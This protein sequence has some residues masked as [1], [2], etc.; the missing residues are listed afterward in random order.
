MGIYPK[1][2]WRGPVPNQG[3]ARSAAPRVGVVHIMEGTLSGTDAWFHNPASQ[4][5][6]HFGIGKDGTVY[7][8]VDTMAVA[9]HAAAANGYSVGVEHEGNTGDVLTPAQLAADADL[10]AWLTP[11]IALTESVSAGWC[12]HGQL[13]AAGG[14]HPDCPGAPILAQLPGILAAASGGP[15]PAPPP[16]PKGQ[17]MIAATS[18]GRGYWCV[19]HDG[20]IYA[21]GDAVNKGQ[22]FGAPEGKGNLQPGVVIVGIAGHGTDGYWLYASDGSVFAYGSAPFMGRPDRY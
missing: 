13:G 6:A 7:Q 18:T 8:W 20:A 14:N 12:G 1:A 10:F 17:G 16:P 15:T 4:V 19:T 21:Y 11:N 5:S 3:G 9:W 22:P 2:Q